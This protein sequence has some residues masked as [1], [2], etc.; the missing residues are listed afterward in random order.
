M[1][2]FTVEICL[3]QRGVSAAAWSSIQEAIKSE[4]KTFFGHVD[5][6]NKSVGYS[7]VMH[8]EGRLA[9]GSEEICDLF[10]KFIQR[11]YTDDVWVTSDPGPE[12]VPD[13][14][15]FGVL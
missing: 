7:S 3:T 1:R 12:H 15:P 13:D 9:S 4:P 5:L 8:F 11:S 10:P 6:K 2:T 14:P